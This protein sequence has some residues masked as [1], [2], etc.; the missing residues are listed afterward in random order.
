MDELSNFIAFWQLLEK[1]IMES[2]KC[3]YDD[4]SRMSRKCIG[5][6]HALPLPCQAAYWYD[7]GKAR[8]FTINLD[9]SCLALL[10]HV[11]RH[12]DYDVKLWTRDTS[13]FE[14]SFLS[15][16][17]NWEMLGRWCVVQGCSHSYLQVPTAGMNVCPLVTCSSY[18]SKPSLNLARVNLQAELHHNAQHHDYCLQC[19]SMM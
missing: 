1:H 18:R 17:L 15:F 14:I 6:L 3:E 11:P 5:R 9:I 4:T 10:D 16:A 2:L 7:H 8:F 19:R 12:G 13:L